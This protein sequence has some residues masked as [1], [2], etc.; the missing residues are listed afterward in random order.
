MTRALQVVLPER[1]AKRQVIKR[2]E[3]LFATAIRV[4]N[5]EAEDNAALKVCNKR[6]HVDDLSVCFFSPPPS[7]YAVGLPDHS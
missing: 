1:D 4:R 6:G 3:G 2:A 5:D 7:R